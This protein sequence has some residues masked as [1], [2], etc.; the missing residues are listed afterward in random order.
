MEHLHPD[1][2]G[3]KQQTLER[4]SHLSISCLL[5]SYLV[6]MIKKKFQFSNSDQRINLPSR[7]KHMENFTKRL[8]E[9]RNL[10]EQDLYMK[11]LYE[12]ARM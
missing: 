2:R 10:S 6:E 3:E 12:C 1:H 11:Q 4:L 9:S 8:A 5:R 7:I